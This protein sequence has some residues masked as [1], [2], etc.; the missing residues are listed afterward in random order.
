MGGLI[1]DQLVGVFGLQGLANGL[2]FVLQTSALG[3]VAWLGYGYFRG[4]SA[5]SPAGS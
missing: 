3:V 2:G 1:T 4:R 5:P